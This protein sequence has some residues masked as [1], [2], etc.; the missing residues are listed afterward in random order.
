MSVEQ[1]SAL[2]DSVGRNIQTLTLYIKDLMTIISYLTVM[3]HVAMDQPLSNFMKDTLDLKR[4]PNYLNDDIKL[5]HVQSVWLLL[6]FTQT[7]SLMRNDQVG[8]SCLFS[9]KLCLSTPKL[10]VQRNQSWRIRDHIKAYF[11][12][13]SNSNSVHTYITNSQLL[14]VLS[15]VISKSLK[16]VTE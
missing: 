11:S 10:R 9:I 1:R 14:N 3:P 15:Y 16:A 13:V 8:V 4:M 5:M 7:D 6:R 2:S 12:S